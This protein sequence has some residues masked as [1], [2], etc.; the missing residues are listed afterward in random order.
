MDEHERIKSDAIGADAYDKQLAEDKRV[1]SQIKK[2]MKAGE[3]AY[4]GEIDK[5]LK[6]WEGLAREGFVQ[7]TAYLAPAKH[8]R[9]Q[10]Q[11]DDEIRILERAI[12]VWE[13]IATYHGKELMLVR[14][15]DRLEKA[16]ALRAKV[17]TRA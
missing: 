17:G 10:R 11:Y 3:L 1:A 7:P 6:I 14:Y 8:Y 5:A 12:W 4:Q 15:K 16:R 9:K 13:N 2:N